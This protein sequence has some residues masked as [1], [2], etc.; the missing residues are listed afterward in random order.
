MN[1]SITI[2]HTCPACGA[3]TELASAKLNV[4]VCN[5]R[6]VPFVGADGVKATFLTKLARNIGQLQPGTTG[7]WQNKAFTLSGVVRIWCREAVLNYWTALFSDGTIWYLE[8]GYGFYAFLK[9]DQTVTPFTADKLKKIRVDNKPNLKGEQP[10]LFINKNE[11][12]KAEVEG[13]VQMPAI[14]KDMKLY[15]FAADNGTKVSII[16]WDPETIQ[17]FEVGSVKREDLQLANLRQVNGEAGHSFQCSECPERIIIKSFPYALSC[18]CTRCGTGYHYLPVK[19]FTKVFKRK[20]EFTP[21]FDFGVTGIIDGVNWEVVGCAQ[22]EE[23]NSYHS[24][25]REYTLYNDVHGYAFLSEFDGH[26]TF[27]REQAETPVLYA[28]SIGDFTYAKEPFTIFNR[29]H[30]KVLTAAGEFPYD[31]FNNE[32][33]QVK[34]FISPPE[35]WIKEKD[36]EEGIRWFFGRHISKKEIKEALPLAYELPYRIGT[37]AVQPTGYKNPVKLAIATFLGVLILVLMHSLYAATLENK[38][39]Y[40]GRLEI[41]DSTNQASDVSQNL[42][43][44]KASSNL[45]LTINAPVSNSWASVSATLVNTVTGKEYSL[46]EGIEYY[47]GYSEGESWTEGSTSSEAYFTA[48][49]AGIYKLQLQA[50]RDASDMNIS[51]VSVVAQYDVETPRNV[52]IPIIAIVAWAVITFYIGQIFEKERWRNSPFSNYTYDDE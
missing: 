44:N 40:E 41:V 3:T 17:A 8:E 31:I 46:E 15:D 5:C 38:L 52:F 35:I 26:W 39:V 10:Y 11:C 36:N 16:Q 27:L 2:R 47:Y 21:Q 29:Y 51:Y 30:Y 37:G 23:K 34:E 24:K 33:T 18:A 48:I 19:G 13:A 6:E 43:F 7:V 22:K 20:K 50:S 4:W 9:P 25:W 49:P 12:W 45:K 14:P 1:N 42:E 32:D 28:E